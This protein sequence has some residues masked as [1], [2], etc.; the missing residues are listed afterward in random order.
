MLAL[1][2]SV[3]SRF[4]AESKAD[5]MSYLWAGAVFVALIGGIVIISLLF[6]WLQRREEKK[7]EARTVAAASHLPEKRGE[8]S[9][10]NKVAL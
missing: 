1:A 10:I 9:F 7:A 4:A 5:E 8:Q 6:S 2:W 3:F